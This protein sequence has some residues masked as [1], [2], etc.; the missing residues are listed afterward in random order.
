MEESQ[1]PKSNE[2]P[3]NAR[4]LVTVGDLPEVI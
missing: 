4:E 1:K 2:R 3:Q